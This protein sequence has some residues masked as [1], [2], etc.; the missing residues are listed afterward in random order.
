M[1]IYDRTL[2]LI[3]DGWSEKINTIPTTIPL[4]NEY[5]FGTR[6]ATLYL[7][8]AETG[9]GKT[10]WA[11]EQHMFV[12]YEYCM[13]VNDPTKLDLLFVDFSLEMSA[14]I[15]MASL[16]SRK[17]YQD[18]GYIY[19]V[20]RLMGWNKQGGP[21]TE[22]AMQV[23]DSYREYFSEFERKLI[24][25]DEDVTATKFHDVLMDVAK[26]T[27]T[28]SR[29]GRWI[30]QCG[31][32]I[33]NNPA[34]MVIVFL[35]TINLTDTDPENKT[36]KSTIDKVSRMMVWF[37]NVCQMTFINIQQFNDNINDPRRFKK[38]PLLTDFEDSKRTIKDA[39]VVYG[40]FEPQRHHKETFHDY[41]V[42][43]LKSWFRSLHLL[44]HRNGLSSKFIPLK[45]NG[46][47]SMFYP[48][49]PA[50]TLVTQEDYEAVTSP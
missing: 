46:M 47:V 25:V 42:L 45:F 5:T 17:M 40:L 16:A 18:Y 13:R 49:P 50:A 27:G 48:M 3:S 43:S 15:N 10:T 38:Y 8:G 2:G 36:I 11:R 28:F 37:R 34:L 32:Y 22:G 23:L 44:K 19:P 6:R 26:R 29:E 14:E 35:D 24:V 21:P 30:W 39:D 31:T 7:Y 1:G 12:P 9:V 4:F 41:K 33:P 20:S